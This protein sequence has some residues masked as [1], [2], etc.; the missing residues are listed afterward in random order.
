MGPAGKGGKGSLN[1]N[2]GNKLGGVTRRKSELRSVVRSF[3]YAWY[4]LRYVYTNERNM[5][6]HVFAAS[7][8]IALCIVLGVSRFELLM[9]TIA[10]TGVFMAELVNT[11][12]ERLIDIV[13]PEYDTIAKVTKDVA[14]AGV[15]LSSFF[16]IVIGVMAF[17]PSILELEVRLGQFLSH[18]LLLFL[19]FNVLVVLPSALG[20]LLVKTPEGK[21]PRV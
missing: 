15:L 20:V 17:Y 19:V 5:R 8:V 4:G 10:I 7:I 11:V 9:I 12:V 21:K 13:Q 14:A 16:A 2:K 3:S 6:F 1:S 18:R